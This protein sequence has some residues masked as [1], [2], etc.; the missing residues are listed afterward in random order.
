MIFICNFIYIFHHV[1]KAFESYRFFG[2]IYILWWISLHQRYFSEPSWFFN[3]VISLWGFLPIYNFFHF[4]FEIQIFLIFFLHIKNVIF[5]IWVWLILHYMLN[6][7]RF[8][9]KTHV[10]LFTLRERIKLVFFFGI[11]SRIK[12]FQ[13]VWKILN[14]TKYI[15]NWLFIMLIRS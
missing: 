3:K 13:N 10:H 1:Q 11:L 12:F 8:L 6:H 7:L 15:L 2:I 14:F 5:I 9:K 4:K